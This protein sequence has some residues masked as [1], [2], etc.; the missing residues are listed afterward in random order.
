[1]KYLGLK[2]VRCSGAAEF[3]GQVSDVCLS[4]LAAF[5]FAI[6]EFKNSVSWA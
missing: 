6:L 2:L 4:V 1:M 3:S 5:I